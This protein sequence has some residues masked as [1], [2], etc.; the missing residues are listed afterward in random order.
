MRAPD[1]SYDE[2]F[3]LP[4]QVKPPT[5]VAKPEIDWEKNNPL[6][7]DEQVKLRVAVVFSLSFNRSP[8]PSQNP[9]RQWFAAAELRN[10]ISLDVERT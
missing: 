2:S 4:R 1:G 3:L 5:P 10:S 6:S 7:L 8:L 9:W